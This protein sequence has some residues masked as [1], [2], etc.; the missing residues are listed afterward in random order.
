MVEASEAKSLDNNKFVLY[1]LRSLELM[2]TSGEFGSSTS[3]SAAGRLSEMIT[4]CSSTNRVRCRGE[5][6]EG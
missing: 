2:A 1:S 4:L 6:G 5:E 3:F